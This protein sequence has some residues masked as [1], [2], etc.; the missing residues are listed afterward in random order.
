MMI[1]IEIGMHWN[2]FEVNLTFG[3][4]LSIPPVLFL[5]AAVKKRIA[6]TRNGEGSKDGQID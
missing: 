4:T 6:T 2:S 1:N 5:I 3:A